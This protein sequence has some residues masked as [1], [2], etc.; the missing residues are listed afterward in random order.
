MVF[1][2]GE[3]KARNMMD[4]LFVAA[5]VSLLIKLRAGMGSGNKLERRSG[6]ILKKLGAFTYGLITVAIICC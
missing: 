6:G 5:R 1:Q 2:R 3:F 4:L